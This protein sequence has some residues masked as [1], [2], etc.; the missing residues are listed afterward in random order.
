MLS[1]I[2][3]RLA[4]GSDVIALKAGVL[5]CCVDRV[6]DSCH[7]PIL[8]PDRLIAHLA[9]VVQAVAAKQDRLAAALEVVDPVDALLLKVH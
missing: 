8:Q 6:A 9:N 1:D 5:V 2:R 4:L 3:E 7:V